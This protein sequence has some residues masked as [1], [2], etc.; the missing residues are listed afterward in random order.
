M[1]AMAILMASCGQGGQGGQG[2]GGAR[3][4]NVLE[5]RETE[6]TVKVDVLSWPRMAADAFGC[7]MEQT[8]GYRDE[9]FNC[10]LKEYENKG[11][12]CYGTDEYYEGPV[13]PEHLVKKV[14]PRLESIE[15]SWEGGSLQNA[16]FIFD[17][18]CTEAEIL[19]AFDITPDELPD[20]VIGI[21]LQDY[22][23][24]LLGFEH[25]GAGEMDCAM[26]MMEEIFYGLPQS[27]MPNYL[28]TVDQRIEMDIFKSYVEWQTLLDD[29]IQLKSN[30]LTKYIHG[31]DGNYDLWEMAVYYLEEDDSKAIVIVQYGSGLDGFTLK[32]DKTLR[33]D[34]KTKLFAEVEREMD[35]FTV[36]EMIDETLFDTPALAA[37]A[38]AFWNKNKQTVRYSE[39]E[40]GGFKVRADLFGYDNSDYYGMQNSVT[41]SRVWNGSRFV[42][43]DRWYWND[44]GEEVLYKE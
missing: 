11:S 44:E 17:R 23:I 12:A 26:A 6:A 5:Q 38:K 19:R 21:N 4:S 7:M 15:L 16:W 2:G 28:K 36:D 35:P 31:D 10:S 22:H 24:S 43:G 39:F 33:Y 20:N 30:S 18:K 25:F 41:T 29:F 42:K 37:K 14:H 34:F 9:R 40:N 32:S 8:F 13:F 3:N 1:A 27:V